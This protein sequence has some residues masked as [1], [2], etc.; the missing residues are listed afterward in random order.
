ME[1]LMTDEQEK[2]EESATMEPEFNAEAFSAKAEQFS[3]L[4]SDI[5][6]LLSNLSREVNGAW[7]QF[8]AIQLVI[9]H[10]KKEL[11]TLHDL[12]M[13]ASSLKQL[14]ENQRAQKE[15]LERLMDSQRA[16]W[17]EERAKLDREEKEYL[18]NLKIQRQREEEEHQSIW[19]AE[20]LKAQTSIEEDLR[21]AKQRCLQ[22]QDS[23]ERDCLEREQILREKELECSRL[24]QE[25]E[26]F[27][28]LINPH[29]KLQ[30]AAPSDFANNYQEPL[31]GREGVRFPTNLHGDD[32]LIPEKPEDDRLAQ[33]YPA[34]SVLGSVSVEESRSILFPPR[35]M[36][37]FQGRKI[38]SPN[39]GIAI[40]RD[41]MT[42]K[43]SPKK[44]LN[45]NPEA[46]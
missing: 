1:V 25:L 4:G 34:V 20:Q 27:M 35:N 36:P 39:T 30:N 16:S 5:A 32:A 8:H 43:F 21:A 19:A 38:D 45:A 41:S 18:D 26:R 17:E 15:N 6:K 14:M 12:D 7:K 37:V 3:I 29:A 46:G 13:S 10:K 33:E 42:L 22:M 24:I 23:I 31:E 9:N 40:K 2:S 11:K 28:M 44:I